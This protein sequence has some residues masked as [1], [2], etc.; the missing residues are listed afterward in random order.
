[1]NQDGRLRFAIVGCGAVV[2]R[3]HLPALRQIA[4]VRLSALVDRDLRRLR[5]LGIRYPSARLCRDV[6]ELPP[7]IDAALVAVPNALHA[8]LAIKLLRRGVHVLCEKPMATTVEACRDMNEAGRRTGAVLVV[9]HHKRF[10]PSIQKAKQLLD[11]GSLG[12]IC[13]ITGSMGLPRTWHTR[14]AFDLDSSLAGGGVLIDDGVHL[15][16]LVVWLVGGIEVVGSYILPE[17]S[18][19]ETDAKVEFVTRRGA[20][21][22]LRFSRRERL[23]NVLCIQG[24]RGFLEF[25]TYDYPSLKLFV[26]TMR[27]CQNV[28]SVVL[29]WP[30]VSPYRS[31]LEHFVRF[32]RRKDSAS[33][34][35]GQEAMEAVSVVARAYS[36]AGRAV[37]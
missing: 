9:G 25:D 13:S 36:Q 14:S 21:G 10:V 37:Q 28:G 17:A 27:L 31:Q 8:P 18:L 4:G 22:V 7:H 15:I 29:T 34:C 20:V 6:D 24:E 5:L 3:F 35:A 23:P 12:A 1:M 32:M 30:R 11:E 26:E 16:D 2:E 33:L 19:V